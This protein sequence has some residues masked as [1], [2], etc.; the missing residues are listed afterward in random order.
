M[1]DKLSCLF[2]DPFVTDGDPGNEC[3]EE[4]W[5][6]PNPVT[7]GAGGNA[8]GL[9]GGGFCCTFEI[10]PDRFPST[11]LITI[12]GGGGGG[13]LLGRRS[14]WRKLGGRPGT[15]GGD[16]GASSVRLRWFSGRDGRLCLTGLGI[17]W[18]MFLDG[19]GF[20]GKGGGGCLGFCGG[21]VPM[22]GRG[23]R[24]IDRWICIVWAPL[25][26]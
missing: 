16:G 3:T 25:A 23:L 4:L 7:G 17:V 6:I 15:G 13:R 20:V 10:N 8:G 2:G 22:F 12:T 5:G 14:F 9:D 18:L 24:S 21:T 1:V 19:G 11:S 26:P